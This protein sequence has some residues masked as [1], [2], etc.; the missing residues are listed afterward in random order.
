MQNSLARVELTGKLAV[1]CRKVYFLRDQSA[2][3]VSVRWPHGLGLW[4]LTRYF[5][6]PVIPLYAS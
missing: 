1:Q 3:T 5:T 6:I 4:P 2:I